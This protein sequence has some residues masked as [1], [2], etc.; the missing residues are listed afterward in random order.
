MLAISRESQ[1]IFLHSEV[2]ENDHIRLG[3][4]AIYSDWF[5]RLLNLL[6]LHPY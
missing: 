2:I 6:V 1:L 3:S 4:E 5:F